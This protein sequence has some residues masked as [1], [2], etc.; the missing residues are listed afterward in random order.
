MFILFSAVAGSI[1]DRF[2]SHLRRFQLYDNAVRSVVVKERE[3][4]RKYHLTMLRKGSVRG[5]TAWHVEGELIH[6]WIK[7]SLFGGQDYVRCGHIEPNGELVLT[8]VFDTARRRQVVV[9]DLELDAYS[10]VLYNPID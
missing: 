8:G 4:E 7:N 1:A 3:R 6:L 10:R 9:D 5:V 2:A